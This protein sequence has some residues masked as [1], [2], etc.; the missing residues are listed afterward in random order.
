MFGE[1]NDRASTP[2]PAVTELAGLGWLYAL[3]VRSSI[4][5]DRRWPAEYMICG[6]REQVLALACLRHNVPTM[7]GRGFDLLPSAV[8]D[9]LLPSL[10]TLLEPAALRWAFAVV[11]DALIEEIG[12]A[13]SDLAIRVRQPL[14]DLAGI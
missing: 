9:R 1:A 8:T 4:A 12:L 11:T 14:R 13:D 2:A 6:E 3:H 5:R 10:V 7:Q